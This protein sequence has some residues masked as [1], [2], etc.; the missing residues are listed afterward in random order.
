[1]DAVHVGWIGIVARAL[2]VA[3]VIK[4]VLLQAFVI[5]SPS[6]EP[7]LDISDRVLVLKPAYRL[8][9]IDRGDVIVFDRPEEAAGQ[10]RDVRPD[11]AGDRSARR[12]RRQSAGRCASTACPSRSRGCRPAC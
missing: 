9:G 1:M 11:Q 10:R 4:L 8:H 2:L 6:M 3:L 7:T 12:D 5:P